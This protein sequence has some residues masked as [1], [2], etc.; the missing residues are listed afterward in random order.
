MNQRKK[1]PL[2][3]RQ[4]ILDAVGNGFA[5]AGYGGTGLNAIVLEAGVTKGGLF[6]HFADKQALALAWIDERLAVQIDAQ[7]IAPL[8]AADTLETL[9]N[10]CQSGLSEVERGSATTTLAA[11]A[12]ELGARNNVLGSRL[13]T[14]YSQWRAAIAGLLDRGKVAGGIHRSIKPPAEAAFLVALIT[15]ASV[16][17]ACAEDP[18]ALRACVTALDDYLNTLRNAPE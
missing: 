17:A 13:E 1:Q 16:T 5:Q 11:L 14:I 8:A 4:A 6:H 7:W 12:A 2:V 9:K 15:G 10:T 3:T 18:T